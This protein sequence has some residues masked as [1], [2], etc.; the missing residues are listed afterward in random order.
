M[1]EHVSYRTVNVDG[2]KLRLLRTLE[3]GQFFSASLA[4]RTR[5]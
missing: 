2:L 5:P 4:I 3:T 1:A